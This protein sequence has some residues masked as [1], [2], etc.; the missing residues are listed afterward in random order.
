MAV[1]GRRLETG[2]PPLFSLSA[3]GLGLWACAR[4]VHCDGSHERPRVVH[5][6]SGRLCIAGS[7]PDA[8]ARNCSGR[9]P[10]SPAFPPSE[11]IF[12][13]TVNQL[14]RQQPAFKV[15]Q[16]SST[17]N[18]DGSVIGSVT[19]QPFFS[20]PDATFSVSRWFRGGSAATIVI[21]GDGATCGHSFTV[22][23]MWLVYASEE[24]GA[25]ATHKCTRTRLLAEAGEDVKYLDGIAQRRPQAVLYGQVFRRASVD[26]QV[27]L[28]VVPERPD[29]VAVGSGQRF[30]VKAARWG[31][32]ESGCHQASSRS[33]WSETVSHSRRERVWCLAVAMSDGWPSV[34][35]RD[36]PTVADPI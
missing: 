31:D 9:L 7:A 4:K 34:R 23:E 2:E 28:M 8:E 24:N 35:L 12:V 6:C 22:G 29:V 18:S 16:Q 30:S 14:P 5:G 33:G 26:G 27:A 36:S 3:P 32:F 25:L 13:G 1:P 17:K 15:V 11:I 10:T 21:R 19:V 20:T